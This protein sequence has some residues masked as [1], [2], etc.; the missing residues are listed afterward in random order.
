MSK[1][2]SERELLRVERELKQARTVTS[3]T[4]VARSALTRSIAPRDAPASP[5]AAASRANEPGR[6]SIRTCTAAL[7]EAERCDMPAP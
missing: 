5:T 2:P 7:N 4:L 1:A 3:R 6:S